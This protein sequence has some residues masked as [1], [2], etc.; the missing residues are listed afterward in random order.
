MLPSKHDRYVDRT[1]IFQT[2]C[3]CVANG[4]SIETTSGKHCKL[5]GRWV[6][7][8]PANIRPPPNVGL[9]LGHRQRRWV[10]INTT[11]GRHVNWGSVNHIKEIQ[12]KLISHLVH[13]Y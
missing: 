5:A 9:L 8:N 11:T 12:L 3:Q 1:L 7:G 13:L 4:G 10:N 6:Y 2:L